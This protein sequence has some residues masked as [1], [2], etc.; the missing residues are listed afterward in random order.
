M[1]HDVTDFASEVLEASRERP[2]LVDF[3]AAWCGPCRAL[4]PVLERLAAEPG[5]PW[6]LAKV[7]TEAMPDV[8]ARYGVSS[9]PNVKLFVDGEVVDEFV[10]ALPE[11]RIRAWLSAAIPAPANPALERAMAALERGAWDEAV[12]ALRAVLADDPANGAVRFA[13]AEA[14][15]HVAPAEAED[16]VRPLAGDER[17][18]DRAEALARLAR[19]AARDAFGSTPAA[20]ALARGAAAVRAAAWDDA[21]TAFVAGMT[22]RRDPAAAEARD[23]GRALF[24]MLGPEHPASER[25][26]RALASAM[27]V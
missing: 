13:L 14:L 6:R 19:L 26:H 10:G 12:A 1:S 3:W 20:A 23:A 4:G 8:A 18:A 11:S 21:F 7:D 9:I 27:N 24:V 5:T 2:V 17:F 15:L 25:Q 22:E 16:E